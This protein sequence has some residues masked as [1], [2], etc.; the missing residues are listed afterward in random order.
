[1]RTTFYLS[2]HPDGGWFG[3]EE[4]TEHYLVVSQSKKDVLDQLMSL[5]ES[6]RPCTIVI[7]NEYGEFMEERTLGTLHIPPD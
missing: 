1:M 3:R 7:Q 2:P 4:G 6:K 5:C